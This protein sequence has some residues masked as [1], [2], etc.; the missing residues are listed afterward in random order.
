MRVSVGDWSLGWF[1]GTEL[2]N[3]RITLSDGSTL[4]ACSAVKSGLTL[5]DIFWGDYD[6]HDTTIDDLHLTLT[7]DAAGRGSWDV[8]APALFSWLGSVRGSLRTSGADVLAVSSRT[9][10]SVHYRDVDSTLTIAAPDAP[11]HFQLSAAGSGEMPGG[12]GT[13]SRAGD[14]SINATLPAMSALLSREISP[15]VIMADAEFSATNVPAGLACDAIGVDCDWAE[16]LGQSLDLIHFSN[17]AAPAGCQPADPADQGKRPLPRRARAIRLSTCGCCCS[18]PDSLDAGGGLLALPV[19][20]GASSEDD[21]HAE[22]SV[23][24]SHNVALFLGRL[25][26]ILSEALPPAGGGGNVRLTLASLNVPLAAPDQTEAVGR[27]TFPEIAFASA[28]SG[29]AT[30]VDQCADVLQGPARRARQIAGSAGLLRV[31]LSDGFFRYENF[32]VSLDRTEINFSGNVAARWPGGFA[33]GDSGSRRCR[34]TWIGHCSDRGQR[35]GG[36]AHYAAAEVKRG[37]T[38]GR[39]PSDWRKNPL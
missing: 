18:A 9:G 4:L 31:Q 37:F 2:K 24:L 6:L 7:R 12:G 11:F 36:E 33:G 25:N 20:S 38:C 27:V 21:F 26:P 16:A 30:L 14:L 39:S 28:G 17:H 1:R 19:S 35:D 15:W 29:S 23:R 34:R 13:L 3:V 22:A 5:W 10:E 8:L 32:L